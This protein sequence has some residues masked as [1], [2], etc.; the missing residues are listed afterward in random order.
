MQQVVGTKNWKRRFLPRSPESM[1]F[2]IKQAWVWIAFLTLAFC[3][4]LESQSSSPQL[5]AYFQPWVKMFVHVCVYAH[6]HAYTC[7]ICAYVCM[8]VGC[9]FVCVNVRVKGIGGK[10]KGHPFVPVTSHSC[11]MWEL[12]FEWCGKSLL[13]KQDKWIL[14]IPLLGD[15]HHMD[16]PR[17]PSFELHLR[18][19]SSE[20]FKVCPL[21][22]AS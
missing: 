19:L 10:N 11:V 21:T 17:L 16:L 12:E 7:V 8:C 22:Y 4:T 18:I 15:T 14:F 20:K 5:K 2:R 6:V 9:I 13:T 3:V 1:G